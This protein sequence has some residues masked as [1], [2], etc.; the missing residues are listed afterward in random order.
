MKGLYHGETAHDHLACDGL[1]TS[2]V[3][4]KWNIDNDLI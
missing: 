2:L 1:V 4:M 3:I